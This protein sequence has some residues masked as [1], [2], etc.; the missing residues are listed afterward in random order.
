M[1]NFG[2]PCGHQRRLSADARTT[3]KLTTPRSKEA[4]DL[5]GGHSRVACE[6]GITCES[7]LWS[8]CPFEDGGD[9]LAHTDAHCA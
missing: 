7:R 4:P 5:G 2:V 9:A 1:N 3:G 6:H 8:S